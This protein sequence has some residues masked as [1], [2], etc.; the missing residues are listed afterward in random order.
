[1][2]RNSVFFFWTQ[3]VR[4]LRKLSIGPCVL[5][6]TVRILNSYRYFIILSSSTLI[7]QKGCFG[8]RSLRHYAFAGAQKRRGLT[9]VP[10]MSGRKRSFMMR[11]IFILRRALTGWQIVRKQAFPNLKNCGPAL[12][13]YGTIRILSSPRSRCIILENGW[14][15]QHRPWDDFLQ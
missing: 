8:L 11:S 15:I 7:Y 13:P 3:S 2:I 4:F 10:G 6:V 12:M 9:Q 14:K 5:P 1:M